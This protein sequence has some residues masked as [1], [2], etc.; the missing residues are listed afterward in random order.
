MM[1]PVWITALLCVIAVYFLGAG[2]LRRAD[3]V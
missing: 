1:P 3:K 2:L